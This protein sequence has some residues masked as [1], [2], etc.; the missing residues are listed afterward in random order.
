MSHDPI[1][2]IPELSWEDIH[3]GLAR[4]AKEK[5]EWAGY[6]MPIKNLSMTIHHSYPFAERLSKTFMPEPERPSLRVCSNEDVDETTELRNEWTSYRDSRTLRI[7]RD[8]KGFFFTYSSRQTSAPMLI[9]T[10][11]AARAWDFEAEIRAQATLRRHITQWAW[12]CYVMTGCFMETSTKS[13]VIYMFR[14]LRPTIAMTSKPDFKGR[15]LGVR[16]LCTLCMHVC[17]FYNDS[18]AGALV[19]TDEIISH[20]LLM[21]SD[22]HEFWKQ[23]NQH[24]PLSPESGL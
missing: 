15:D 17:G 6:P 13:G 22:E 24:N 2:A 5:G 21:R 18:W 11:G 8:K 19:P 10:L 4:L 7:F 3:R 12:E 23:A 16:M 1:D 9:N 14:R 20:L